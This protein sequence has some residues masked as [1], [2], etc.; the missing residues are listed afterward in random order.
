MSK[1]KTLLLD[2]DQLIGLVEKTKELYVPIAIKYQIGQ[3]SLAKHLSRVTVIM[4]EKAHMR[5]LRD[6]GKKDWGVHNYISES[7]IEMAFPNRYKYSE[8]L[9]SALI[10]LYDGEIPLI[11]QELELLFHSTAEVKYDLEFVTHEAA[12]HEFLNA[13]FHYLRTL[14]NQQLFD[15]PSF[16]KC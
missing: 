9:E 6:H 15:K 16:I 13:L 3:G 1:D 2:K 4:F 12:Q 11:L 8:C 5:Y 14:N 7:L 10:R